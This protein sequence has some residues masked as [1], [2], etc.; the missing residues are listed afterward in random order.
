MAGVG[1]GAASLDPALR[2]ESK[3][4]IRGNGEGDMVML[5]D[6][7][8]VSSPTI[9]GHP[10]NTQSHH[11]HTHT[12]THTSSCPAT[13]DFFSTEDGVRYV[14]FSTGEGAILP[15]GVGDGAASLDPSLRCESKQRIRGYGEG[16]MVMMSCSTVYD[17]PT[18]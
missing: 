10:T 1:D 4:R 12:H 9:R 11:T 13:C 18:I 14:L 3:Q 15:P 7:G 8:M 5:D 6:M 16:D 17:N 2:C